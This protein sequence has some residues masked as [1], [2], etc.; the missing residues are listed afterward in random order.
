LTCDRPLPLD[1]DFPLVPTNTFYEE[2]L[3]SLQEV[4]IAVDCPTSLRH[5]NFC[6]FGLNLWSGMS[7]VTTA[8]PLSGAATA[9][10][11]LFRR[12]GRLSLTPCSSTRSLSLEDFWIPPPTTA[13]SPSLHPPRCSRWARTAHCDLAKRRGR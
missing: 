8:A 13:F 10:S 5:L 6:Y 11:A 1:A 12:S 2:R 7:C 4:A 3:D 9:T